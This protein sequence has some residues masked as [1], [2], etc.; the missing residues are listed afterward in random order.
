M[1][2]KSM[3]YNDTE[4]CPDQETLLNY[5]DN[6]LSP[7][8]IRKIEIHIN[9]CE[10]CSEAIDGFIGQEDRKKA[11]VELEKLNAW[12]GEQKSSGNKLIQA[13]FRMICR[14][15]AMLLLAALTVGS[16]YFLLKDEGGSEMIS[17]SLKSD[18][19]NLQAP[20]VVSSDEGLSLYDKNQK[21][22]VQGKASTVVDADANITEGSP[23]ILKDDVEKASDE[24][25]AHLFR[26]SSDRK[27]SEMR[28]S[29]PSQTPQKYSSE[30]ETKDLAASSEVQEDYGHEEVTTENLNTTSTNS[31]RT[32][33]VGSTAETV[34][35]SA[36]NK[37][38][39]K[40]I[41]VEAKKA[42]DDKKYT[43]VI[44]LL[45]KYKGGTKPEQEEADWL[46]AMS[47]LHTN[48]PSLAQPLLKKIFSDGIKYR[49]DAER[50]LDSLGLK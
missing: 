36:A 45:S 32:T 1:R 31:R 13:N 5:L 40:E 46:L 29:A 4:L 43:R 20:S 30:K 18:N 12:M 37:A 11:L 6:K 23:K 19:E 39:G 49:N 26:E 10:F 35:G 3:K 24:P 15:A 28:E 2:D 25:P 9:D 50:A 16:L 14:M 7:S 42:Y 38:A 21:E 41:Y 27:K 33:V 47:Y 34:K 17:N 22:S 44:R 48:K 8:E